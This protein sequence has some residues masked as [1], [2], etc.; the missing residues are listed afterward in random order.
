MHVTKAAFLVL[1]YAEQLCLGAIETP[2]PSAYR[3]ASGA[4]AKRAIALGA[5][6][7]LTEWLPLLRRPKSLVS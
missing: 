5:F 4:D 3:P 2:H 6:L 7:R 1:R